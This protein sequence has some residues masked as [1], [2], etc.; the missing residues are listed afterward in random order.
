MVGGVGNDLVEAK[1]LLG[2]QEAVAFVAWP[3]RRCFL[4]SDAY[5]NCA[6]SILLVPV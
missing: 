6:V 5:P 1:A 2:S 3:F 4:G